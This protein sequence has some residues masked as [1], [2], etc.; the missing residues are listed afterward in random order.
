MT[1]GICGW[2]NRRTGKVDSSQ[3]G[4]L[5]NTRQ[6]NVESKATKWGRLIVCGAVLGMTIAMAVALATKGVDTASLTNGIANAALYGGSGAA[7]V[8]MVKKGMD[9]RERCNSKRAL[10]GNTALANELKREADDLQRGLDKACVKEKTIAGRQYFVAYERGTTEAL[11]Q[12]S[13]REPKY[14]I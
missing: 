3:I 6:W 9:L 8:W 4:D 12:I 14:T 7:V 10:T 1:T 11:I 2:I 13:S 5:T